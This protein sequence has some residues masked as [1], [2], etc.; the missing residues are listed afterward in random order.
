LSGTNLSV[1]RRYLYTASILVNGNAGAVNARLEDWLQLTLKP[2][3]Q[4]GCQWSVMGFAK[5][6]NIALDL[7]LPFASCNRAV[8]PSGFEGL[9]SFVAVV[10]HP[11]RDVI[12]SELMLW[13]IKVN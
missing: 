1:V 2:F 13:R 3:G 5:V 10:P 11:Q 6:R 7:V 4:Q 12:P 9:D 8:A